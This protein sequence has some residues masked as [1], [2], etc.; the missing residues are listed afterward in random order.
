MIWSSRI[1]QT[2][3]SEG[4][5]ASSDLPTDLLTHSITGSGRGYGR[6]HQDRTKERSAVGPRLDER[7]QTKVED[8]E[9]D[10]RPSSY[11]YVLAPSYI[12]PS[13]K[14]Q[15]SPPTRLANHQDDHLCAL[16]LLTKV[17]TGP[18]SDFRTDLLR[19]LQRQGSL[20]PYPRPTKRPIH[21]SA[22]STRDSSFDCELFYSS[23]VGDDMR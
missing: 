9:G 18:R 21:R 2:S 15:H 3:S 1:G 20:R 11:Q 12:Q 22:S 19:V 4:H 13:L 6:R 16:S 7:D 23:R 10:G 14:W 5:F 8:D 17:T